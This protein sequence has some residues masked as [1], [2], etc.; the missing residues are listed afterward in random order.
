VLLDGDLL[1]G[2]CG[3]LCGF[4]DGVPAWDAVGGDPD[5][6]REERAVF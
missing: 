3:E 6:E 1:G 2:L 5:V 4:V